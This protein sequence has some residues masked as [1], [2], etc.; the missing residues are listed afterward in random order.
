MYFVEVSTLSEDSGCYFDASWVV[1]LMKFYF[2]TSNWISETSNRIGDQES[3][4]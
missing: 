4:K 2:Q 3:F 1:L